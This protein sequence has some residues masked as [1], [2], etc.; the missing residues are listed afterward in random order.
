MG[1][2]HG[3]PEPCVDV[4]PGTNDATGLQV[5]HV[6]VFRCP[7]FSVEGHRSQVDDMSAQQSPRVLRLQERCRRF[8]L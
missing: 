4:L 1:Q 7:D 8:P 6:G 3:S 5:H 2:Y